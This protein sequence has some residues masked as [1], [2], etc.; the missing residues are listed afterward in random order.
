MNPITVEEFK[1]LYCLNRDDC[2]PCGDGCKKLSEALTMA[3]DK[4]FIK[5]SALE[6]AR[7]YL[8]CK[9]SYEN[10]KN[11]KGYNNGCCSGSACKQKYLYEKAISDYHKILDKIFLLAT[12]IKGQD[13]MVVININLGMIIDLINDI[14]K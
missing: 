14:R 13:Q 5:Q 2:F 11:N 6:E 10:C 3:R 9:L 12:A 7:N 1:E 4:G 8:D